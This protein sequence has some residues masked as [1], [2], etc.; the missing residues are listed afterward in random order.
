MRKAFLNLSTH[1]H[2]MIKID[3][4]D[5]SHATRGVRLTSQVGSLTELELDLVVLTEVTAD[6]RVAIPQATRDA[7][8]ELGWTP[9][10]E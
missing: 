10:E 2:G 8:T 4:V 1:G 6:V 3:G 5:L 9:P 7:L